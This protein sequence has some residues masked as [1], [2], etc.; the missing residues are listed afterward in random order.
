MRNERKNEKKKSD[1]SFRTN[2]ITIEYPEIDADRT[3]AIFSDC[4]C[5]SIF[6]RE[7]VHY[8]TLIDGDSHEKGNGIQTFF[9]CHFENEN[10]PIRN[11]E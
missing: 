7:S 10:T 2:Q 4:S 11:N 5:G 8:R 1:K 3:V 9:F 6:K